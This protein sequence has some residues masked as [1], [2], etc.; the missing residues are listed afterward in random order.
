MIH[1]NQSQL[2]ENMMCLEFDL[3]DTPLDETLSRRFK[4]IDQ[5]FIE[6]SIK[7]QITGTCHGQQIFE[8]D[9]ALDYMVSGKKIIK[10]IQD[11]LL[12]LKESLG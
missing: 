4:K 2:A 8:N 6:S 12:K 5:S 9:Q 3:S 11:R 10:S 7:F 1:I